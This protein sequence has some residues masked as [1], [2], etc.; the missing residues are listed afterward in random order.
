MT[1][2]DDERIVS[3]EILND[4]YDSPPR[5]L[6][7]KGWA[8]DKIRPLLK[9]LDWMRHLPAEMDRQLWQDIQHIEG[10][11]VMA[12]IT[13]IERIGIEKGVLQGVQ[14]GIQ[15]GIQQGE[16]KLLRKLLEHRFGALPTWVSDKLPAATEQDLES[17]GEPVLTAPTLEVVFDNNAT[18]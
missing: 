1:E 12:Y 18:H 17:W 10:E 7:R 11:K 13:S 3:T 8:S 2:Q 9:V 15:Q 14:Q 4:D 16:S 6:L 5:P